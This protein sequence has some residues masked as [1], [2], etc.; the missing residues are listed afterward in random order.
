M[1][2]SLLE[3]FE[4]I[5]KSVDPLEMRKRIQKINDEDLPKAVE[6]ALGDASLKVM[7]RV[8]DNIANEA[9]EELLYGLLMAHVELLMEENEV[10][11]VRDLILTIT[12]Y[13]QNIRQ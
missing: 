9:V 13:K 2:D 7:A 1:I 6:D 4:D 3:R 5:F 12:N 8:Y 10:E 11:E